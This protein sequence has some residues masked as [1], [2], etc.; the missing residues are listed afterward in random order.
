MPP[1]LLPVTPHAVLTREI[2]SLCDDLLAGGAAERWLAAARRC[3]A[4]A[5]PLD[6][7]LAGTTTPPSDALRALEAETHRVDWDRSFED[8][9]TGA[10]LER[11]MVSGALEGQFLRMLV[12]I[13]GARRVLEVGVFTGYSALAMA[14]A[15]PEG[16][17]LVGCERDPFAAAFARQQFARTAAGAK[18][19]L[20]V[21]AGADV[22]ARLADEG[23]AFDLV[24]VDADKTGY[25]GY[26]RTLLDRD[27]VRPG[28]VICVDNTLYKGEVYAAGA[29]SETGEALRLFNRAVADEPRVE[30]VVLPLRDG[31]TIIR[32]VA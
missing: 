31:L 4:L 15:L 29:V 28:G 21:G 25:L 14:E 18:I 22:L 9:Q 19:D 27:L 26:F 17:L 32:R 11:E 12:A 24:F 7:Y 30:Q 1:V 20:R 2:E 10:R 5:A 8:G 3:R 23:L 16:G 13:S 6:G